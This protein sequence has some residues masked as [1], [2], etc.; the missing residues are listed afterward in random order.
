[1]KLQ[2]GQMLR[3]L[4]RILGCLK[5]LSQHLRRPGRSTDFHADERGVVAVIFAIVFCAILLAVAIA[6]DFGRTAR[7]YTRVQDALDAAALAAAHRL[8]KTDQNTQGP[9]DADAY[10]K[11]NT[12]KQKNV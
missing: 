2:G 11:A 8:G 9:S 4:A 12:A 3:Y 5:S 6:I 10:F 1:M 7:E